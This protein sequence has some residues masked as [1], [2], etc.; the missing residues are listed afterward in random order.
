MRLGRHPPAPEQWQGS[1]TD[2]G[3][4]WPGQARR[5]QPSLCSSSWAAQ[6][7]AQ[8]PRGVPSTPKS[9]SLSSSTT[10]CSVCLFVGGLVPDPLPPRPCLTHP[11]C[12]SSHLSSPAHGF[13]SWPH[14]AAL[15]PEQSCQGAGL[16][17][18][19]LRF[20]KSLPQ[21]PAP[22]ASKPSH[23][24]F[25]VP[26]PPACTSDLSEVRSDPSAGHQ[27]AVFSPVSLAWAGS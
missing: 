25:L 1:Q 8:L 7:H 4:C 27:G 12:P 6:R 15:Q 13:K 14:P 3:Q 18:S 10:H 23:M 5:L 20:L 22:V 24:V 17:T 26:P 19:L 9:C 2:L 16:N 21:G 11:G